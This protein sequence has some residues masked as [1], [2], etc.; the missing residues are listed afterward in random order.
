MNK[1]YFSIWLD[2]FK[3]IINITTSQVYHITMF[4]PYGYELVNYVDF[5]Q[6]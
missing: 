4:V 3:F 5:K 1:Y 6:F 2:N